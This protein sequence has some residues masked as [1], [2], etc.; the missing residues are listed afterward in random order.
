MPEFT[1]F[2]F[3]IF[4]FGFITCREKQLLFES[5]RGRFR[6][7]SRPGCGLGSSPAGY[8]C[9]RSLGRALPG[10]VSCWH[11]GIL[12]NP[13]SQYPTHWR[14]FLSLSSNTLKP[15]QSGQMLQGNPAYACLCWLG[16]SFTPYT[17][18][19]AFPILPWGPTQVCP[20]PLSLALDGHLDPQ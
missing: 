4:F 5:R 13:E 19:P 6:A 1:Y 16:R 15:A 7:P 14:Q 17:Y 3:F 12:I 18:S 10:F 20:E 9:D 2:F 11:Q 8:R